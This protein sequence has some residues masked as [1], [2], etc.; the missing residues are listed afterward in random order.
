MGVIKG[1]RHVNPNCQDATKCKPHGEYGEVSY[2][3]TKTP[4]EWW[5]YHNN[6]SFAYRTLAWRFKE[7]EAKKE[8]TEYEYINY[9]VHPSDRW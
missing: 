2:Y 9:Y 6:K 7:E 8:I 1:L 5:K 4:Q 3:E